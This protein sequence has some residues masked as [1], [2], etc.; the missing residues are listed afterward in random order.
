MTDSDGRAGLA[1]GHHILESLPAAVLLLDG[2]GSVRYLNPVAEEQIALS[3]H[4]VLHRDLFREVLPE[5][6]GEGWGAHFR[7]RVEEGALSLAWE[8]HVTGANGERLLGFGLSSYAIEGAWWGLL[9]IDDR[10][11]YARERDARQRLERLAAVGE[12]TA[13]AGHEIN[14]PLA[15]ISGFAQLLAEETLDAASARGLRIIHQEAA[16]ISQIVNRLLDF[17][18]QQRI[19]GFEAV[20]LN[21]LLAGILQLRRYTLQSSGVDVQLELASDLPRVEGSQ[22]ELQRLVLI[23][24]CRAEESLLCRTSERRLTLCTARIGEDV[25]LSMSDNGPVFPG[26][27]HRPVPV[28]ERERLC[29]IWLSSAQTITRQHGGSLTLSGSGE[30]GAT[31]TLR[32]PRAGRGSLCGSRK[33]RAPLPPLPP[34]EPLVR[35]AAERWPGDFPRRVLIAEGEPTMRLSISTFLSARGFQITEAADVENALFLASRRQCDLALIDY[36]LPGDLLSL[37][38]FFEADPFWQNRV[39]FMGDG[40][41]DNRGEPG[42]NGSRL[43][44][45]K[46]FE[47]ESVV[48]LLRSMTTPAL[49]PPDPWNSF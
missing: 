18:R 19:L 16:R 1:S 30:I 15:A 12:L 44:L 22:G 8:S 5:L 26:A 10:T 21:A 17:S 40:H 34:V 38:S 9:V 41:P 6:E 2:T 39:V 23:L 20:D 48:R 42:P 32:L 45:V 33:T 35:H 46:P 25:V 47:L 31:F 7:E 36:C 14:N 4:A 11:R 24:L 3:R 27:S 13:G 29:A 37:Y 43:H 49:P 28:S